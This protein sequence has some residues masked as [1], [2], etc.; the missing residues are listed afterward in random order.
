MPKYN[1]YIQYICIMETYNIKKTLTIAYILL[2]G[3]SN[4]DDFPNV[5][6]NQSIPITMAEYN[7]VYN[8]IWGYEYINGGVG[9]II[10]V[11]GLNNEFI[12]Y[13]RACTHEGNPDCILSSIKIN[14]PILSCTNCCNSKFVIIDGSVSEGPA[15]K[16]LK[17]YDTYFDGVM[18]YIT[19]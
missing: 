2:L 14:N 7:N 10:I 9:G 18:L 17:Q 1:G 3:C 5:Y 15:N 13:D 19:N 16:A 4:N 11:Q 6:V 12:A 8:N